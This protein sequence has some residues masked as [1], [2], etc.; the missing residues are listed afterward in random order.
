MTRPADT[1]KP[2]A[3]PE[4]LREV[5]EVTSVDVAIVIARAWGGQRKWLPR[6]PKPDHPLSRLVGAAAARRIGEAL[7]NDTIEWP[8]AKAYLNWHDARRLRREGLSHAQIARKL[9]LSVD[10]VAKLTAG[11]DRGPGGAP[12]AIPE[13]QPMRCPT[14]GRVHR[15]RMSSMPVDPR[16]MPLPLV[17]GRPPP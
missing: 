14:C 12:A 4:A 2:E 15:P 17:P 1:P 10:W 6:C 13:A 11:V 8:S 16:Q 3:L 5:A 7:G 9:A